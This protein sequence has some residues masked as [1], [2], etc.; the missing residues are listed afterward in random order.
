VRTSAP[1]APSDVAQAGSLAQ[2]LAS[3]PPV[4][5][6][7]VARVKEAIANG[8]FPI[9]PGTIADNMLAMRIQLAKGDE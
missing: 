9:E 8:T 1:A 7:R 2:S 3:A 6:D 4:D 5:L